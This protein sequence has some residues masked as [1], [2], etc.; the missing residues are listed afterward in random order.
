MSTLTSAQT[1][2][3]TACEQISSGVKSLH[4]VP[5]DN[6]LLPEW[7][8]GAHI[9]LMLRSGRVRQYSLCGYADPCK[10]EIAVLREEDGRGGSAEIHD[11][12]SVGDELQILGLRNRFQ[13]RDATSYIFVAGGIG[14]TP[15]IAMIREAESRM[16][17]WRLAYGGRTRESMAF[18]P[19]LAAYGNRVH[20]YPAD[21]CGL[22]D[23]A[24]E[25]APESGALVYCCG[26]RPLLEAVASHCD[27]LWP[28]GVLNIE[29]FSGGRAVESVPPGVQAFEIQL[30]E[31]GPV[32]EVDQD[33]S[34]LETLLEAGA[35]P[36]YSCEEGT[37]GSCEIQVLAGEPDHRDSLLTESERDSGKML[38]CV[39]RC[40]GQR[41]V[42]DLEP[43]EQ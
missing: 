22:I 28:P 31:E 34:V 39:S 40:R 16:I 20:L 10:Y 11:E 43:P 18:L 19:E 1:V 17:S 35:D 41:L 9:D 7:E 5:K 12:V 25:L 30:G 3:V 15:I 6:I 29:R 23:L 27:Q 26:P 14:I 33:K 4:L 13:L 32:L 24:T 38:I 21:E 37:C 42:L 8:P 2:I 36:L